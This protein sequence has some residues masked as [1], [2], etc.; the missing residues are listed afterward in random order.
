MN[1]Q[2]G[3]VSQGTCSLPTLSTADLLLPLELS[4]MDVQQLMC[5]VPSALVQ[6]VIMQSRVPQPIGRI[7][8]HFVGRRPYG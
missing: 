6:I 3:Y 4:V 5:R 2:L 1:I 8:N 7:A